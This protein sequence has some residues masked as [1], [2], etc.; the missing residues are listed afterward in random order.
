M[1]EELTVRGWISGVKQLSGQ[2]DTRV[3]RID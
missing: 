2:F 1:G 3:E